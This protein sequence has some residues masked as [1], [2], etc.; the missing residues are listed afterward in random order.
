LN[1]L[2]DATRRFEAA[3][4]L[5]PGSLTA[6]KGLDR[7]YNRTGKYKELL[8]N[9]ER[10]IE[11]SATP[12]QK[13]KLY[14]RIAGIQDEEFL[15]HE[16]AA[17]AFEAILLIDGAHEGA[18][19]ALVRHYRALDRW[20]DAVQLYEKNLRIVADDKRKV[21]LYLAMGRVLVDQVG[22]PERARKAY[23]KVLEID[24]HHAGALESLAHV[25]AATGDA[26]AALS[27]IES[28]AEKT[29]APESRAD[30]W[31]RAAKMLEEKGDKDGAIERY[32][33]ALDA[34]P[35]NVVAGSQL[36]AAYLS[37]GDA[38]SAVELIAREIE[39]AD[40]NLAKARLYGEMAQL[41][42]DKLR[43]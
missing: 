36:R 12:R 37:R 8:A 34:Q 22:S 15:N 19:S 38:T 4:A 42:R 41:L 39:V 43:D 21:D 2:P 7:I 1:N 14:E 30:L 6:L 31:I 32:K 29:T 3:L 9:L 13:I 35:K 16:N 27:A 25:R 40:G 5:D 18:L 11:L 24:P 10:Q 20:E 26:L 17:E 33:K 28:L 23:E